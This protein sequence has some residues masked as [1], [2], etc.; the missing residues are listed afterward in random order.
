[1]FNVP[2]NTLSGW[3]K[4][5]ESIKE[6]YAKLGPKRRLICTR[7][8]DELENAMLKWFTAMR[9]QNIPLSVSVLLE[10][11][12]QFANQLGINDFKQSTGWQD[13]FKECHGIA[14]KADCGEAKSVDSD[15]SDMAGWKDGLSLILKSY[16]A[17]DIYNA[18]E[19]GLFFKLM[20]DKTLELKNVQC[21]GG[22]R[23][24]ER[25]TLLVCANMTGTD[26]LPL[27]V[28]SKYA[29]PRCF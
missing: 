24:K 6:G 10:E 14:F 18:D 20:P 13:W 11:A 1:M 23:S 29:C 3:L 17:N 25:L 15:L 7:S 12:Q 26:K 8:L 22:K 21:R 16:H 4:K 27:L 5:A 19:T 28:F 2:K 9:D